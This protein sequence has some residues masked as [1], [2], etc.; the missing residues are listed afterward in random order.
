MIYILW[1]KGIEKQLSLTEFE[2]AELLGGASL[3]AAGT[4]RELWRTF[5]Q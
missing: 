1:N 3:G 5:S 4:G 2:I